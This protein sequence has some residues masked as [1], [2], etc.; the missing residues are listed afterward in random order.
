MATEVS[1][2]S[3]SFFWWTCAAPGC[4]H[5]WKAQPKRRTAARAPDSCAKC[6]AAA[7]PSAA[8]SGSRRAG[9]E[10]ERER[11]L[12]LARPAIAAQWD[13]ELNAKSKSPET[14][15]IASTSKAWWR[16]EQGHRWQAT[17]RSRT[18]KHDAGC[19]ACLAASSAASASAP[20]PAP[21]APAPAHDALEV[22]GEAEEAAEAA[23]L[24][25]PLRVPGREE[26][27]A[28]LPA[29]PAHLCAACGR[30]WEGAGETCPACAGGASVATARCLATEYPDL[31][32]EWDEE[33]NGGVSPRGVPA[34][35]RERHWWRCQDTFCRHVYELS[36]AERTEL[37]RGC[38]K[39]AV[40]KRR[41]GGKGGEGGEEGGRRTG[42]RGLIEA[43]VFRSFVLFRHEKATARAA[44]EQRDDAWQFLRRLFSSSRAR[45]SPGAPPRLPDGR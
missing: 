6:A 27:P 7:Q 4:G 14:V 42:R 26:R 12:L 22:E 20:I 18:S 11:S 3:T 35:S 17:V 13:A 1:A 44:A 36:P 25:A 16:C 28:P 33:L 38:P 21:A 8:P 45:P 10:G 43:G 15:S 40:R 41:G 34:D 19:P 24:R 5:Q 31:A 9:A 32:A 39:C 30:E 23:P 2:A 29:R 37:G